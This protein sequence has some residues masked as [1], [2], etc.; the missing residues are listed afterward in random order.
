MFQLDTAECSE[1]VL[2]VSV[3]EVWCCS[4]VLRETGWCDASSRW[5]VL[6]Y[7]SRNLFLTKDPKIDG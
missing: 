3:V 2:S 1:G 5:C 7:C 4:V 6:V